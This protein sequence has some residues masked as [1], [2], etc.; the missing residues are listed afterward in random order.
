[1]IE[2]EIS[3]IKS[4]QRNLYFGIPSF[5]FF[6]MCVL[7]FEILAEALEKNREVNN[8]NNKYNDK[9]NADF[10]IYWSRRE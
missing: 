6:V 7:L 9:H 4:K 8:R 1:M 10:R 5:C 2:R 3:S